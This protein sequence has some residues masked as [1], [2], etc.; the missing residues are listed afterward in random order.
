MRYAIPRK[1]GL[2]EIEQGEFKVTVRLIPKYEWEL[3]NRHS[4]KV[5]LNIDSM[6]LCISEKEFEQLF[7]VKQE[8]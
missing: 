6:I 3:H 7:Y 1:A 8:A 4:G 2:I 5:W